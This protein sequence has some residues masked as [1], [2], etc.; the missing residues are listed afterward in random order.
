MTR[1]PLEIVVTAYGESPHLRAAL[2]SLAAFAPADLPVSVLDDASPTDFVQRS[3]A[4]HDNR[5]RYLRN[6]RNLGI[7]GSFNAALAASRGEY[8]VLM[9]H[10]DVLLPGGAQTYVSAIEASAGCDLIQ[11]GVLVVDEQDRLVH[12]LGDRIK[13]A[14]RPRSGRPYTG[15]A[16]GVSFALGQWVYFPTL[17]WHTDTARRHGFDESTHTAMDLDLLLR[18]VLADG[19]L[20]VAHRPAMAYRRHPASASART[21][22]PARLA[23]ELA[24]YRSFADSAGRRGWPSAAAA[25]R[26]APTARLHGLL[27]ATGA[28]AS[29]RRQILGLVAGRLS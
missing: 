4:G 18:M 20:Y 23:E 6:P 1:P 15:E 10:D 22:G 5:F 24:V 8:T 27:H 19:S 14:L 17:A 2:A 3:V 21:A 16:L 11:P 25:A 12:P 26:L 28:D 9:G 29:T 13:A 7:A